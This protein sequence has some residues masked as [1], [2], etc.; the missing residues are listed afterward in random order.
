MNVLKTSLVNLWWVVVGG[1]HQP[2][3]CIDLDICRHFGL[4]DASPRDFHDRAGERNLLVSCPGSAVGD[5]SLQCWRALD[6]GEVAV[7]TF[8]L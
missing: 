5:K 2:P 1:G 8:F 3:L 6:P 7:E 4:L